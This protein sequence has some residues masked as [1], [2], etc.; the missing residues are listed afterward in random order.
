MFN[1]EA[2]TLEDAAEV[3]GSRVPS[4][5]MCSE[6]GSTF[7]LKVKT[8]EIFYFGKIYL[9]TEESSPCATELLTNSELREESCS[10]A[11]G[12]Q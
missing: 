12:G 7:S 5:W 11:S 8:C 2:G 6:K 3:W 9:S 4:A 1:Q 10:Q